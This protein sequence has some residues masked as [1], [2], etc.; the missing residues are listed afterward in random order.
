VSVPRLAPFVAG[1]WR[2]SVRITP[3]ANP[4]DRRRIV[5]ETAAAALTDV[6][7]AYAAAAD[8][9]ARWSGLSRAARVEQLERFLAEIDARSTEVATAIT[10]EMG[11]PIREART[12]VARALDTGRYQLRSYLDEPEASDWAGSADALRG[13]EE[14]EPLGVV[15]LVTPWNFPVATVLRK[16]IPALVCGNAVLLKPAEIAPLSARV[17]LECVVSAGLPP[18]LVNALPGPGSVVGP[19]ILGDERLAGVSFTG[20]TEVGTGILESIAGREVSAQMELGG[21]NASVVL[22]DADLSKAAS[23]IADAA[24]ICTGQWCVG[25][26]RVVVAEPVA[27]RFLEELARASAAR[28]LGPGIDEATEVGP[29]ASESQ[30]AIVVEHVERAR[31]A[32]AAVLTGG[33][34]PDSDLLRNGLFYQPTVVTEV[35]R[36]SALATDEVF[37]PVVAALVAHDLDD[38]IAITNAV[39]YGLSAAIFTASR[40]SARRFVAEADVGKVSVN[41][42]TGVALPELPLGGRKA[43]GR[44][45]PENGASARRFFTR[46]KTVYVG[47]A[48]WSLS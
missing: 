45:E 44:G 29:L 20:S 27:A 46:H 2:D 28:M 7:D 41:A 8:A 9:G 17:L 11:K 14:R 39:E 48:D 26:S 22:A 38:A 47:G 16:L 31:S 37:G 19:L 15:A 35:G 18:G 40:D 42:H 6:Q 25:T 12:E 3:R 21:K 24:F 36:T 33:R 34:Q 30:L 23:A 13:W 1:E 4:A 43:S 5:G 10:L 32:G